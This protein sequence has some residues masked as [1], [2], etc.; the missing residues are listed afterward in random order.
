M[1]RSSRGGSPAGGREGGRTTAFRGPWRHRRFCRCRFLALPAGHNGL[2]HVRI[3]S[4]S[5]RSCIGASC[6][7]AFPCG[8][9]RTL[10]RTFRGRGP[11]WPSFRG[12]HRKPSRH[13]ALFSKLRFF[14]LKRRIWSRYSLACPLWSAL[15]AAS[16]ILSSSRFSFF[17]I[18]GA[19]AGRFFLAIVSGLSGRLA[20]SR[21]SFFPADQV[22]V[23]GL[24]FFLGLTAEGR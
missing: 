2:R 6:G 17:P 9:A 24:A 14:F 16:R 4:S 15:S 23:G 11:L 5:C 22:P 8:F 19:F 13:L 21:D 10:P 3:S 20:R 7:R 1:L 18:A 12:Y